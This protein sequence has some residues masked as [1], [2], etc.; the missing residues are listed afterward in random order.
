MSATGPVKR[1]TLWVRD[2]EASLA[3]Y[4][5]ALGLAVL[6]RKE[7]QGPA[8]AKMVGLEQ[9]KLRIVHLGAEGATHGWV[10]LYEISATAPHDMQSLA[11]PLSFPAYGQAT[12]VFETTAMDAVL[13]RLRACV[14][15]RFVTAPTEYVKREA[16][17]VMP[18]G[19]YS[20]LIFFDPDGIPVS[21][22][23]Y[24]PL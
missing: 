5:D 22:M 24:A 12:V 1:I 9:A 15:V 2:L 18:A 13:V 14:G 6:E 8:I 4:R 7:L 16:S 21:V 20:E 10:G 11:K 23:G 17:A 19:R 3:V